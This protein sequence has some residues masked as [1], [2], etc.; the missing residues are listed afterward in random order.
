MHAGV[1]KVDK[2]LHVYRLGTQ[3]LS[4]MMIYLVQLKDLFYYK[5]VFT[6][7]SHTYLH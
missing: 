4:T 2:Y 6:S 1:N 5:V 7:G 3:C